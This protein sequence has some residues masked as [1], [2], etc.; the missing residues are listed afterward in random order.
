VVFVP[1]LAPLF[2]LNVLGDRIPAT[3]FGWGNGHDRSQYTAAP[4]DVRYNH[5]TVKIDYQTRE[6]APQEVTFDSEGAL[7]TLT[8]PLTPS[9]VSVLAICMLFMNAGL[10][11]AALV[12]Y[13]RISR[14]FPPAFRPSLSPLAG[15]L[16]SASIWGLLGWRMLRSYRRYG[17]LPRQLWLDQSG[18]TLGHRPEGTKR[19]REWPLTSVRRVAVRPVRGLTGKFAAQCVQIRVRGKLFALTVICRSRNQ[20]ALDA[21]MAAFLPVVPAATLVDKIK[22]AA[23]R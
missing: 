7:Q 17:H 22:H 10:Q 4:S 16:A 18:Q 2:E 20:A 14:Q 5:V 11:I 8:F 23:S 12:F 21:F 6:R 1:N 15:C 9:W 3:G 13:I 19:Q